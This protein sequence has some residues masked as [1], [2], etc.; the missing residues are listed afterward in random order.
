MKKVVDYPIKIRISIPETKKSF[1]LNLSI[2]TTVKEIN[3]IISQKLGFDPFITN[4]N[5]EAPRDFYIMNPTST[6]LQNRV[7][8]GDIIQAKITLTTTLNA[9]SQLNPRSQIIKSLIDL[10]ELSNYKPNVRSNVYGLIIEGVCI[11]QKCLGYA[12]NMKFPLGVGEFNLNEIINGIKCPI[13]PYR[14]FGTNP[15]IVVKQI[16]L[17][18]CYFKYEGS[19]KDDNGFVHRKVCPSFFKIEGENIN[20]LYQI[21]DKNKWIDFSITVKAM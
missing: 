3:S 9:K 20:K 4:F 7:R 18:N 17:V 14:E 11:N 15:L 19:Y 6:L 1:D 21:I 13:C 8:S 5:F 16:K 10:S 2:H 12:E